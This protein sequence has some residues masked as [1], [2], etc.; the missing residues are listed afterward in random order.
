MV[1]HPGAHYISIVIQPEHEHMRSMSEDMLDK[2][3]INWG[4][5]QMADKLLDITAFP[6]A[7]F[8]RNMPIM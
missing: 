1:S 7:G 3:H 4:I 5:H 2:T 6:R 8:A